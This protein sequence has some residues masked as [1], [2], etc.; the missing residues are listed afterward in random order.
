MIITTELSA[1]AMCELLTAINPFSPHLGQEG[2][3]SSFSMF[4]SFYNERNAFC[5]DLQVSGELPDFCC[6]KWCFVPSIKILR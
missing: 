1:F 4:N 3:Y 2:R 6:N 5:T